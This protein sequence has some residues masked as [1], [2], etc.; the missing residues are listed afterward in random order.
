MH[1]STILQSCVHTFMNSV[2]TDMQGKW[3][4]TG[5]QTNHPGQSS[6]DFELD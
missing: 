3:G 1:A 6:N 2:P 5:V 4:V